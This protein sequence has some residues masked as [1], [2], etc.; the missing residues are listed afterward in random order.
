MQKMIC[1]LMVCCFGVAAAPVT[2]AD[3]ST[4][5]IEKAIKASGG[6]KALEKYKAAISKASGT[7][8]LMGMSIKYSG[9]FYVL[10]P[11]KFHVV[12]EITVMG[13]NITI[14]QV[15]NGDKAWIKINNL[16]TMEM[17]KIQLEIVRQQMAVDYASSLLPLLDKKKYTLSNVGEITVGES[18]AMGINVTAK[19]GLDVNLYFDKKTHML[20]KQQFQTKDETG[21]EVNQEA[22]FSS[23]K[24][25]KGL[26]YPTKVRVDRDGKKFLTSEISEIQLKETIPDSIFTKP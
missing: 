13:Q 4:V 17:T 12:M 22:Y 15:V 18:K 10:P 20:V 5:L 1:G 3:E 6:R 26:A 11:N 2:A 25:F 24:K 14:T 8:N 19:G 9:T 16:A 23:Y 21:K 7:I